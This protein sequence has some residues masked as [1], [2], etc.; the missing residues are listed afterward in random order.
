MRGGVETLSVASGPRGA[1]VQSTHERYNP[2]LWSRQESWA[3]PW[4]HP[5]GNSGGSAG[6]MRGSANPMGRTGRSGGQSDGRSACRPDGRRVG[7]VHGRSARR[8]VARSNHWTVGR[9][10]GHLCGGSVL[11][12]SEGSWNNG[13][14]PSRAGRRPNFSRNPTEHRA[15]ASWS[16]ETTWWLCR[17]A[18][19][20]PGATAFLGARS[21]SSGKRACP[22]SCSRPWPLWLFGP[23]SALARSRPRRQRCGPSVADARGRCHV[24]CVRAWVVYSGV[25]RRRSAKRC[26]VANQAQQTSPKLSQSPSSSKFGVRRSKIGT[27]RL[28]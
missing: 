12:R 24:D 2:F 3:D 7:R 9:P 14:P 25:L 13:T 6:P 20:A 10:D 17:A 21:L 4:R 18:P 15:R 19:C 28:N 1:R 23:G 8:A 16:G 11:G 5:V 26:D 22:R 27:H